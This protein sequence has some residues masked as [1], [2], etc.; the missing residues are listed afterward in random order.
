MKKYSIIHFAYQWDEMWRRGQQFAFHLS[1]SEM[2]DKIVFVEQPLTALSL[3]KYALG[4][5]DSLTTKRWKRMLTSKSLI[6]PLTGNLYV[7]TPL[8]LFPYTNSMLLNAIDGYFRANIQLFLTK[9]L[10]KKLGV[11]QVIVW[12]NLPQIPVK[13]VERLP[14]CLLWY[15]CTE[16]FSELPYVHGRLKKII[17]ENDDYLT[18]RADVVSVVSQE[19]CKQKT[20]VSKNTFWMP[21][22]VNTD[23]FSKNPPPE[24]PED[25]KGINKPRLVCTGSLNQRL[26]WDLLCYLSS[27]HPEW[28]I[29]LIGPVSLPRDIKANLSQLPS[30]HFLGSKPYEDLPAYLYYSDVCLLFEKVDY[31][32]ITGDSQK[33]YSYLASG[34]PIVSMPTSDVVLYPH[35]IEIAYSKEEF[36]RLVEKALNEDNSELRE[37]R[38][39][40]AKENSWNAR[41]AKVLELLSSRLDDG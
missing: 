38:V 28:S 40:T 19:L 32:N 6:N 36:V 35:S 30:V 29:I 41:V 18:Q 10:I 39:A 33:V 3:V 2:I 15:D 5:T 16:D 14:H 31:V 37:Q 8:T 12:V 27:I 20:A 4:R 24:P 21:N 9:R 13:V 22:A 1:Q 17:K 7:V 11:G 26:D 25:I 34:K 23:L